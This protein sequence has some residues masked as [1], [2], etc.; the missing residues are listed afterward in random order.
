MRIVWKI[1]LFI[2]GILLI[3]AGVILLSDAV[4]AGEAYRTEQ[5]AED[6]IQLLGHI[7][8]LACILCIGVGTLLAHAGFTFPAKKD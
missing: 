2:V 1:V 5:T 7:Y 4:E 8:Y 6:I 3:A